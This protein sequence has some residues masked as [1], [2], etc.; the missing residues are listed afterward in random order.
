MDNFNKNI[1]S[2]TQL[3]NSINATNKALIQGVRS[4][5]HHIQLS[6]RPYARLMPG[7]ELRLQE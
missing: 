3:Q 7:A 2:Q 6:P 5:R 4:H 1:N